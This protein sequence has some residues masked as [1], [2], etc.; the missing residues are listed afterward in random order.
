MGLKLQ[1]RVLESGLP[2][3]LRFL[4]TLLALYGDEDGCNIFPSVRRIA[5]ELD[6]HPTNVRRQLKALRGLGILIVERPGGGRKKSTRY[7]MNTAALVPRNKS[8]GARD[9]EPVPLR[10]GATVSDG[11]LAPT[12][13]AAET[14]AEAL[15]K[16]L[17]SALSN[18][19]VG[20]TQIDR[21]TPRDHNS[22]F[23]SGA[24]TQS[25]PR[26]HGSF[27]DLIAD[28]ILLQEIERGEEVP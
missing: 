28:D 17:A 26:R 24:T 18:N 16:T 25:S 14:S 5:A 1:R 27:V 8:A 23:K 12:L 22:L 19:Q 4:A 9:S 10:A 7:R 21:T 20:S 3:R 15:R 13:Q 2:H 11:S 6:I